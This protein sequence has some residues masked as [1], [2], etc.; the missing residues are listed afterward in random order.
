MNSTRDVG[1]LFHYVARFSVHGVCV[2][3]WTLSW[4]KFH[5]DS[6]GFEMHAKMSHISSKPHSGCLTLSFVPCLDFVLMEFLLPIR[7]CRGGNF[8]TDLDGFKI[9]V[10]VC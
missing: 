3:Q 10:E 9:N 6:N 7:T 5:T 2:A 8:Q 1:T 4:T